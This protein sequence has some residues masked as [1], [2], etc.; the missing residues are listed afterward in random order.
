MDIE[1]KRRRNREHKR[2]K[3]WENAEKE[4][5]RKRLAQRDY[6]DNNRKERAKQWR[7]NNQDRIRKYAWKQR[8][9]PEPTRPEPKFCEACGE[10]PSGRYKNLCLDHN[11]TTG[12]FR[13]WLC[14]NCNRAL[15]M[16]K[17]NPTTLRNLAMILEYCPCGVIDNTPRS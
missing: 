8:N 15:G 12:E 1:E 3:Y 10:A 13:A 6:D 9:L 5:E 16:S 11:H 14:H 17:D 7:K 4:R 2:K